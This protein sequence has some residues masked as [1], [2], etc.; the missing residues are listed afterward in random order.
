M[1]EIIQYVS[2]GLC[3]LLCLVHFIVQLV[4]SKAN[5]KKID[6]LC[7]Q[8]GFPVFADSAHT[9]MLSSEQMQK[10]YDFVMTF[11]SR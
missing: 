3:A 9:C 7:E 1:T 10:L 4:Y 2:F 8:C 11:V 5:N 6:R